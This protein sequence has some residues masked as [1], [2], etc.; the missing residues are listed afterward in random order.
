[1]YDV[2]NNAYNLG[3][4]L[5]VNFERYLVVHRGGI[6]SLSNGSN[7]PKYFKRNKMTDILLRIGAVVT[8]V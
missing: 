3:G 2:Y 5:N 6:Y 7:S 8:T 1:M 4:Q